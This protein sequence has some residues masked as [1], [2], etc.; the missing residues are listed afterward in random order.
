MTPIGAAAGGTLVALLLATAAAC[1]DSDEHDAY[2]DR[3]AE[4][5]DDPALDADDRE[6]FAT[7]LVDTIGVE[8]LSANVEI[9]EIGPDFAPADHGIEIDEQQG[10]EFYER[11]NECVDVR[12]LFIES[13][14]A[15]Q[16]LPRETVDCI[17]S[18]IDDDLVE[19]IIVASFTQGDAAA[20]DPELANELNAIST[21]CAPTDAGSEGVPP[22]DPAATTTT[23][24]PAGA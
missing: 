21:E 23:T 6:C 14:S 16:E 12:A 10:D 13:L 9:D 11:L 3:L 19:R 15:G 20:N 18:T 1:S 8:V 17:E 24:T 22:A 2:V 4:V 7:S 5:L